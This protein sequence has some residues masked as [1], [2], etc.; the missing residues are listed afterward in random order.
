MDNSAHVGADD[1]Y[2]TAME[3]RSWSLTIADLVLG[4]LLMLAAV[5]VA[6]LSGLHW[7]TAV[8]AGAIALV[9]PSL[10]RIDIAVRRLPN[11]LTL[12]ILVLS[13]AVAAAHAAL[14]NW[15]GPAIAAG[16]AALL[17]VLAC[18]GGMGMG[19]LK[20]GAAIVLAVSGT[21]VAPLI[22]LGASFVFGGLTGVIM[23]ALG[24]RTL[25]FGPFL[26]LG[27]AAALAVDCFV[28]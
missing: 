21:P 20:L 25:P 9:A 11:P 6:A 10:A 26:L 24:H 14:G 22:A 5:A 16:C 28:A 12:P 4:G 3:Q 1:R 8:S 17:A 27:L 7:L 13:G 23:L 18:S 2:R 15:V 19:D